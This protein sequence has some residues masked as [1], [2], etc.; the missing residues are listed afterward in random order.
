MTERAVGLLPGD[1]MKVLVACEESQAITNE[2]RKKGHLAYSC[3]IKRCSGGHPEW[4]IIGD[5]IRTINGGLIRTEDGNEYIIDSWDLIIAH[6]PCTYLAVC[7]NRWYYTEGAEER[8]IYRQR[9]IEFFMQFVRCSCPRIAIE[10]PI[11]IMSTLYKKPTQIL[12][13][14]QFGD[15]YKKRTCLWLKGLPK[16]VHT[17][18]VLP[19]PDYISPS[20][21][22]MPAWYSSLWG[23][24][25]RSEKR[26]KTFPGIAKAMADQWG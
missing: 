4:H 15:P 20:G 6:P 9:A 22:H 25:N 8:K 11:G 21:K 16:L 3:D 19:E 14:Y 2:F 1:H 7:G 17:N 12:Q 13:P 24:K 18:I 5:A 26:S 23:D 10:N